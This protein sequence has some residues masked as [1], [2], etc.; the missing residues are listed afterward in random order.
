MD[1][2]VQKVG[3]QEIISFTISMDQGKTCN[4]MHHSFVGILVTLFGLLF[5]LGNMEVV[6][7]E[8]V[9]TGW[10]VLVIIGGLMKLMGKKCT[11]C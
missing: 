7:M 6:T 4:C 11:C 8:M 10:P 1:T 5:L 2:D 9:N 3:T